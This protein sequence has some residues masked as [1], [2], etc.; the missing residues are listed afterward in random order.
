MSRIALCTTTIH[1]PNVLSLLRHYGP[2]VHFF[3]AADKKTPDVAKVFCDS[4]S[5][6]HY[7]SVEEQ[8]NSEWACLKHLP[9]NSISRRN[10]AVL[11]ALRW[12]AETI[13]AWDDDNIPLHCDYF[14]QFEHALTRPHAGLVASSNTDWF[15]PGELLQPRAPHRGF[16]YDKRGGQHFEA[17]V[18][19]EVGVAAGIV[20]GDPDISVVE[21][22]ANGPI[23]HGSS[24][25]L[26]SGVVVDPRETW[27]VFNTQNTAYRRELA[28]AMLLCPQ[29]GRYDDIIASLVTQRVMREQGLHVRFGQPF[30]WQQRNEHNLMQDLH[31][32]LWGMK[33]LVEIAKILDAVRLVDISSPTVQTMCCYQTLHHHLA[34]MLPEQYDLV[35]AWADDMKK[36]GL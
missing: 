2:Y 29:F 3:V 8:E 22:I 18:G 16:P 33:H 24:C 30:A 23:V 26:Q 1:I 31:D 19:A 11:E 20:I 17:I 6:C 21:R 13:I 9:W 15:D 32:E 35:V 36:V 14:L 28:P 10:I 7:I 12:G 34:E 25:L 27:T 5:D 4:V